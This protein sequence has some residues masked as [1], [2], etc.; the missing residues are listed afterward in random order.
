MATD[1][2]RLHRLVREV[3]AVRPLAE[4]PDTRR[5]LMAALAAV[6]PMGVLNDPWTW[7]RA[8]RLDALALAL[9]GGDAGVP[10]GAKE[11]EQVRLLLDLLASY[12]HGALAAYAQVP[13]RKS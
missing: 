7:P 9:V 1:T 11:Q 10:E 3:A 2:I 8:R 5:T 4:A 6:Y 12:R 13:V